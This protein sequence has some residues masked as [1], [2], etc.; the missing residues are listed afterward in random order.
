MRSRLK[1]FIKDEGR[2]QKWLSEKVNVSM[3]T[4]SSIIN[5]KSLPTLPVAFRIA[6]VLG[7]KIEDIWYEEDEDTKKD[8]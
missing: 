7:R 6:K 8:L 4:I 3:A 1:K 5:E 2:T